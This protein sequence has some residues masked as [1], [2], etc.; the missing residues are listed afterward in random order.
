VTFS[1]DQ[2]CHSLWDVLPKLQALA[3][4]GHAVRHFVEDVDVAFT[5]IGAVAD[6]PASGQGGA[7]RLA[8]ERFYRSGGA[9]WG[10]ALFY[11]EFLGRLPL[12]VRDLEP[13]IGMKLKAL[14]R[15]LDRSVDDLYDE[16]SPGD[17]W[18]LIGPSYVGDRDHHR[19]IG[20][21]TVRETLPFLRE[22][23]DKA[24][25]DM[26]E[27]F[28]SA[29]SQKRLGGWLAHEKRLLEDLLARHASGRLVEL[30][31]DWLAGCLDAA[32]ASVELDFA[33]RFFA[34]SADARRHS[35]LEVFTSRYEAA[36]KLY[37]DSLAETS[38]P[39]RPLRTDAGELPFFAVLNRQG[40]LVRTAVYLNDGQ[41]RLARPDA[42]GLKLLPGG[43]VPLEGLAEA[44]VEAMVAKA[45][46]LTI[47]V[48]ME[49]A[50]A[51]LAL[52][53][54]GSLYMPAST[55]LAE[56]L[57]SAGLL[58]G[59][60]HPVLRVRL[61]LL[62]RMRTLQTPIRLPEHLAA[63]FGADEIPAARLGENYESLA[64]EAARR[65]E[66]F[67][68]ADARLQWQQRAFPQLFQQTDNL[69]GRRR[70]LAAKDPKAAEVRSLSRQ[71]KP[72]E[73]TLLAETLRCVWRDWQVSRIDYWDSRGA[74]LPW[75]MALGGE[76][77]YN[78]VIDQ[79]EVYQEQ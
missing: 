79:A 65:L 57:S 36:A 47:Q 72:I 51:A 25:A 39:L 21:L 29:D 77:F 20:D 74:I 2:N 19:V 73:Q 26:L 53:Y 35:L 40:R 22:I 33:S 6:S 42:A 50:G 24:Q 48:R 68:D 54:R 3:R 38:S 46:L 44:G 41:V 9:D 61:R 43:R 75:C 4:K 5:A 69:D 67:R 17:N 16:F 49:G 32:Q 62:D 45:I 11:S 13:M 56:K 64:G 52:P 1:I 58:G 55:C 8:L 70:A 71:I 34:C 14:A 18:Q 59:G 66:S 10:A 63:C 23:M 76:A 37:N 60:L 30:Y 7:L 12:E 15:Q 27:R 78:Q 28:P 31:R